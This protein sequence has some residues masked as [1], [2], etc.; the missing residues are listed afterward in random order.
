[1]G[2]R[3]E[4]SEPRHQSIKTTATTTT[5]TVTTTIRGEAGMFRRGANIDVD[6]D[7]NV[8]GGMTKM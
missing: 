6:G 4:M 1:M 3:P 7:V 2:Y 5:T 8:D